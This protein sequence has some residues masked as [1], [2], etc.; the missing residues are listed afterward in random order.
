VPFS[1]TTLRHRGADAGL[2]NRL[3]TI[4]TRHYSRRTEDVYVH[5]IRERASCHTFRH[6]FA[7]PLLEA[8]HDLRTVQELLRHA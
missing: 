2:D 3:T 4:R 8:G 5:W 1:C 7:T 6:S